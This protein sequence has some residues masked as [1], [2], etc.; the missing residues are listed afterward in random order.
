MDALPWQIE[1]LCQPSPPHQ[2][3]LF[4]PVANYFEMS[5]W[6][7]EMHKVRFCHSKGIQCL[8]RFVWDLNVVNGGGENAEDKVVSL[9]TKTHK[10]SAMQILSLWALNRVPLLPPSPCEFFFSLAQP[11]LLTY[12]FSVCFPCS[13]T[14]HSLSPSITRE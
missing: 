12:L 11:L 10:R 7:S 4:M 2:K 6:K 9:L 1:A 13:A 5:P 8:V 3:P 14:P